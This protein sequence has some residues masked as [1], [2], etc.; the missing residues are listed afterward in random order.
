MTETVKN[1]LHNAISFC[2]DNEI[3]RLSFDQY[4]RGYLANVS[5]KYES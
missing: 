5:I 2:K 3:A 1:T 4:N